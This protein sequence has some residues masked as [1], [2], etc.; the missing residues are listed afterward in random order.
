[1]VAWPA[2][3]GVAEV[4][5]DEAEAAAPEARELPEAAADKAAPE[6]PAAADE[7]AAAADEEPPLQGTIVGRR[8]HQL[9]FSK[10]RDVTEERQGTHMTTLLLTHDVSEPAPIVVLSE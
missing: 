2:E 3:P 6:A 9:C 1:M 4:T 5:A 8:C 10:G 7:V